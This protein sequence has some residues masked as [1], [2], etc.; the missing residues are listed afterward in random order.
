[1]AGEPLVLTTTSQLNTTRRGRGRFGAGTTRRE[2]RRLPGRVPGEPETRGAYDLSAEPST[3]PDGSTVCLR[4]APTG[5]TASVLTKA[6]SAH[7][8]DAAGQLVDET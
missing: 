8:I 4:I 5:A 7:D 3:V 2:S 6:A 1:M